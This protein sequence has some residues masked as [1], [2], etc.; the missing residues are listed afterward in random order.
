MGCLAAPLQLVLDRSDLDNGKMDHKPQRVT[1]TQKAVAFM[2]CY[3][4]HLFH[5]GLLS[6]VDWAVKGTKMTTAR[7]YIFINT[8]TK[9]LWSLKISIKGINFRVYFTE[10]ISVL[11]LV[12]FGWLLYQ[13]KMK[14]SF[15]FLEI[16]PI[17]HLE[18]PSL[19]NTL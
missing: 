16:R 5:L 6:A 12:H 13:V 8:T 7:F 14:V 9:C 18:C 3:S 1:A 10:V 15:T 17:L 11:P 2:E 4:L 19:S